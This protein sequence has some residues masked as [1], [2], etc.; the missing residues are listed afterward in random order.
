MKPEQ[1]LD[2]LILNIKESK[3]NPHNK[4]KI[5]E[6]VHEL[7][8]NNRSSNTIIKYLYP[9]YQVNKRKWIA[10]DFEDMTKADLK[11]VIAEVNSGKSKT[12]IAWS[13]ATKKNFRITI[14][15]F[16]KWLEGIDEPRFY[17]EKVR[18]ITSTI[19]KRDKRELKFDDMVNREEVI[20]MSQSALNQMHKAFVWVC[21][22]STGRPEENLNLKYSDIK[23]DAHGAIVMLSG[24]KDKRPSRL[25]SSVEPLRNWLR[26]HP[27]KNQKDYPV[28]VTQ[29]SKKKDNVNKWTKIQNQGA[30]KIL[31]TLAKRAG[32]SRK[33]SLYSL[34]KGRI[35]ELAKSDMSGSLLKTSVGWT[36]SSNVADRY[37]K[38]SLKD[39]DQAILRT[40]GF[41]T[42]EKEEIESYIQCKWCG[43]KCSPGSLYC[44]NSK[45]NKPLIITDSEIDTL[46]K[47]MSNL[48]DS[49][50]AKANIILD[51]MLNTNPVFRKSYEKALDE[52]EKI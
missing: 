7:K 49:K 13:G 26:Y 35:T 30:N 11:E 31:K 32:I 29:F 9:L 6:F 15:V 21:F 10:K 47:E 51:K 25:V 8:A 1:R 37:I 18:W 48:V 4:Q 52:V 38:F 42:Q 14:K 20:R 44:E 33:V 41:I 12:G 3:I 43:T 16:Y 17:P 34:R 36:Q 2:N 24:S 39:I 27:L 46:R 19:P 40:N 23:F 28:W 22:E 5:I 45:C 50:L